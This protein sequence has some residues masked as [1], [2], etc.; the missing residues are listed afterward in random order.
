MDIP[1]ITPT[2]EQL[3]ILHL[4]RT[5]SDPLQIISYAGCGK[6]ATLTMLQEA[7]PPPVLALAFNTRIRAKMSEEFLPTTKVQTFN[8]LGLAIWNET[9]GHHC[10]IEKEGSHVVKTRNLF[11]KE[12]DRFTKK[13][14]AEAW[15]VYSDIST[16][17]GMAKSL[18]YIPEGHY[19]DKRSL[20]SRSNFYYS[21]DA[22]P[23]SLVENLTE[24]IL[25]ASISAAQKGS[26]DFDDQCYMPVLFGG[27][28][29]IHPN[30]LVDEE[31]DLSPINIE[32][33]AKLKASRLFGVGDPWQSIYAFRGAVQNGMKIQRERFGM[34]T[35]E[36][37]ICFRCPEAIVEN[38]RWRAPNM[39]WVKPGGVVAKLK[40]PSS[41]TFPDGCAIICRNNAPLF[42]LAFHLLSHGRSISVGG[43]DIGPRLIGIMKKLG[44]EDISR[45]TLLRQIDYWQEEREILGSSTAADTA[46]CMRTFANLGS[47]LGEALIYAKDI[48]RQK[49][50]IT[51]LTGHKAKGLEWDVVYHLDPWLIKD[52][53]QDLNLRYV[54][55]TRAM[56]C[57]YEI[58]STEIRR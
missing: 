9:I 10:V 48:L 28:F 55:Q 58:N 1:T 8:A 37:S 20:I 32:M 19:Q 29:P 11:K 35:T 49:G 42:K 30:A 34:K 53:E 46:D 44:S 12:I 43:S 16:A 7:L 15:E 39:K 2:D 36:L 54:I 51:L 38:A 24:G 41:T 56:S 14:K 18:G 21:L 50:T 33:L 45:D 25:C 40:S 26:I 13:A 3:H 6:T 47:T 5:T 27:T 4:A 57:Y 52:H 22:R 17:V 23:T 31:Q